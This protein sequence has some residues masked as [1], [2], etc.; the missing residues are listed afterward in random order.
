MRRGK[1]QRLQGVWMMMS[2]VWFVALLGG[3]S[4]QLSMFDGLLRMYRRQGLP[5]RE[6]RFLGNQPILSEYDFIVVGAGAAGC[7]VTNRLTEVPDWKVLLLEAGVDDSMFTDVP[8]FNTY[9]WWT[10]HNWLYQ[11]E[12]QKEACLGLK[13]KT[14]PWPAGKGMGGGTIINALIYTRGNTGDYDR[15]ASLGNPGWSYADVL[16]YFLKSEKVAI[17]RLQNSPYHGHSGYLNVDY[18][19]YKTPLRDAFME[20]GR[21]LG[22]DFIDYHDPATPIGFSPIQATMY[23]GR[24]NGA[25]RTFL[26]PIKNRKNFHVATQAHVT[27]IL[28]DPNTKRA[29]GVEFIKNGRKRVVLARKEV[30]LS[31]GAFNSPQLMML[32]GIGPR[33][34]LTQMGIPVMA[35]L[36]VGNNLQEHISMAGLTFLVNEGVGLIVS[37][38]LGNAT[39]FALEYLSRGRGPFTMLGCEA[40]GYIKTKYANSSNFPDIEYIFVPASLALDSGSSLRKTMEITDDLYNAVWKDVGGKDAWTVWPMLLYPKSTGFVRLAST[41]PLKP[42]K[43]IANFLTEKIDVDVMAEALQTVVELSKTRAFQKF[44][45]KL[46]DVPIPGCAQ[47]PFGS[48]DYWGCSAR[49]ITT[50]L[51]HQCCTNKMGPSTDPGAV[52]DPSLRVYGVSGLRVIDTSVMP[53]I[54]GGHTMATAYMIAEKGSDLIKEMW[55]SQRFFK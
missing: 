15:W 42:P 18:S 16:P 10:E 14:C 17:P 35:D 33:D 9:L 32:S 30:I 40:L 37:R 23:K 38:L 41:N 36:P 25:S 53:V 52:V 2:S 24:R 43:I 20:A 7:V 19:P 54:T 48:L 34:H 50:Q 4:G 26:H 49:Y 29:Y 6:N 28:I 8:I 12:Q 55:L 44:G 11:T 5:F 27:R 51:H 3:V 21:E 31:A 45:S 22:Y 47:F 39:T 13:D 1:C 46:H